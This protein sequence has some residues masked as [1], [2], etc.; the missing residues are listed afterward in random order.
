MSTATAPTTEWQSFF[1]DNYVLIWSGMMSESESDAH[2]DGLWKLLQLHEGSR[3]LDAGCG[4]GRLSRR[5]AARGAVVVGVDQSAELLAH[6]ERTRGDIPQSGLRYLRH[7]LRQR[8]SEGGFA[9]AFNVFTGIGFGSEADDLA[10]LATMHDAV[11]PGG[12]VLLEAIQRDA[13]VAFMVRGGQQSMCRPDGILV[14]AQSVF[15]PITSRIDGTWYWAGPSSNG[16]KT[17]SMHIYTIAELIRLL[18]TV[19]LRV[20]GTFLGISTSPFKETP[21]EMGGR[22]GLLAQRLQG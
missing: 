6:A 19:G 22:I 11:R 14:L 16:Q 15:D 13:V 18:E 1:D 5:L 10:I 2:C 7:D 12:L 20:Q 3:V 9:A 8:L 17:A 21:P 4:Y